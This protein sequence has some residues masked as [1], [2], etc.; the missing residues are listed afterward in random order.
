MLTVSDDKLQICSASTVMSGTVFITDY[1]KWHKIRKV[2]GDKSKHSV[3]LEA[4]IQGCRLI[5]ED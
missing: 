4:S 1:I 2:N 3:L 5:S